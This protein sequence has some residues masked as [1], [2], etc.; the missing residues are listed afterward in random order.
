M[1]DEADS[2]E[3][4]PS[5]HVDDVG[6]VSVETDVLGQQVRAL[7]EAGQRRREDLA[8]LLFEQVGDAPPLPAAAR[9]AG[10][11][12]EGLRRGV[13]VSGVREAG[14]RRDCSASERG[15]TGQ[16]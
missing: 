7:A 12:H 11:E 8:A 3:A 10:N 1:G 15:A 6:D 9:G 2:F 13:R 16:V 5:D 4:F 14:N